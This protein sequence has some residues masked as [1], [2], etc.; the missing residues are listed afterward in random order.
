MKTKSSLSAQARRSG[1][2]AV[3]GGSRCVVWKPIRLRRRNFRT[4]TCQGFSLDIGGH[5][6]FSKSKEPK[7]SGDFAHHARP[8]DALA[9]FTTAN[10]SLSETVRSSVTGF[11]GLRSVSI[12]MK[13]PCSGPRTFEDWVGNQ[14][15]KRLFNTFFKVTEKFGKA[16]KISATGPLSA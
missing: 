14:F 1:L 10:F 8:T 7:T 5:R 12:V 6:F 9:H 16:A 2:P 11:S 3:E 13:A 15:G 4:V